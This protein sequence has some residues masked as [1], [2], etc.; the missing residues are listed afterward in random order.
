MKPTTSLLAALLIA[1][2]PALAFEVGEFRSGMSRDQVRTT[3]KSWNFDKS[4]E[5]GDTLMAY[6]PPEV[7]A[8][9]RYVFIF[10]NDKLVGFDQEIAGSLRNF[11]TITSNYNAQYGQPVK[12]LALTNVV[13]SGEKNTLTMYW[14]KMGD[15]TGVRYILLPSSEQLTITYQ[16]TN[17][18]WQAP[19]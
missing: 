1:C 12:V 9:R 7:P 13:G 3:L 6:D 19:R 16:V 18:C 5:T 17:N 2:Q 10:C 11:I 8:S 15:I 14:R 4:I